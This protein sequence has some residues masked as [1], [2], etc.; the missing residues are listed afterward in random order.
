MAVSALK[1][2]F[3]LS[4]GC[5]RNLTDSEALLASLQKEGFSI[6]DEAEDADIAIVNTCG[7]IEDAKKESIDA[8]VA[9]AELKKEGIISKIIVCGCLSQRYPNE[10]IEEVE[11]IDGVFGT[12]DLAVL[13]GMIETILDGE[14]IRH[15][16]AEPDPLP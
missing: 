2:I 16:S 11:E 13:P 12:S 7:F 6:V 4:L 9:L 14:K 3:L 5:P 1:K 15:V 8:I 10:L